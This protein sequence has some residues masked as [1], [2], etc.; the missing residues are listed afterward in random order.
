MTKRKRLA[1]N[2][3]Q[4]IQIKIGNPDIFQNELLQSSKETT[5]DLRP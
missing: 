2:P 5:S 3:D 1:E 4:I